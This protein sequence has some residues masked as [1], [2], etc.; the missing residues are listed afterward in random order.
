MSSPVTAPGIA[1]GSGAA[2]PARHFTEP[3]R[4]LGALA[5]LTA[6]AVFLFLGVS[7]LIFVMDGWADSFGFRSAVQFGTFVGPLALGLPFAAMLVATHIA[8]MVPRSRAILLT[9]LVEYG[10]S[11]VFGVITFLGAF[12]HGLGSVRDTLEGVLGRAVWLGLLVLA[13]IVVYRVLIGLYPPAPP[14]V[15][16]TYA[17]GPTYPGSPVYGRP[18]PGRPT[19]PPTGS[20]APG[21]TAPAAPTAYQPGSADPSQS[22][23]VYH[24]SPTLASEYDDALFE[25]P[26]TEGG[27][28]IV[29][30]P[31]VPAPLAIPTQTP[32]PTSTP[33]SPPPPR[34]LTV[35][36]DPTVRV[37][38]LTG[39]LNGEATRLMPLTPP[40]QPA[41]PE[42][43]QQSEKPDGPAEPPIRG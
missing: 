22:P 35:E 36:Y 9:V 14:R 28:P 42:I 24:P 41:P 23:A 38:P 16:A 17:A 4:Q 26:A 1:P 5:L 13:V 7:G 32:P 6:N 3:Y 11:A 43:P 33:T 37:T 18:Y 27:W 2:T 8:P 29:P 12:A 19:Y 31:P 40:A 25:S 21:P 20:T 30:P 15:R 34:P 39:S 10:V